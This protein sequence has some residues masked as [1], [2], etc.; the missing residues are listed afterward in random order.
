MSISIY[1][2]QL[3]TGRFGHVGLCQL[4]TVDEGLLPGCYVYAHQDLF[5]SI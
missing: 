3:I 5:A 1:L 4:N 2:L